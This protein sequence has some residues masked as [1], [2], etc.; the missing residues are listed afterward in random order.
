MTRHTYLMKSRHGVYYLRVVLPRH[1][2]GQLGWRAG[3]LRLSL[4]TKSKGQA[5]LRLAETLHT[6]T[7]TTYPARWEAEADAKRESYERGLALVEQFGRLNPHDV[8]RIDAVHEALS[9]REFR[10]LAY[11]N[12]YEALVRNA[13]RKGASAIAPPRNV[14][15]ANE[16]PSASADDLSI[17]NAIERFVST[18][19]TDTRAATADKYGAQCRLFL[20]M[21]SNGQTGMMI[22]E[23]TV[24]HLRDYVDILPKLPKK[25]MPEEQRTIAQHIERAGSSTMAP[26]TR[27]AHA[28]AVNMLLTW[29]KD[30][31]YPVPSAF[32]G[33]LK[34][35]RKKPKGRTL[36]K[37]FTPEEL[38]TIFASTHYQRGLFTR[39]SDYW[40]PLLGLFTGARK[41][42]S[43]SFITRT[44]ISILRQSFG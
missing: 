23:L 6:M 31:A 40:L 18:K 11:V 38:R 30:Q 16:T 29:A 1:V 25:V 35:L 22:S 33:I 36:E 8:H 4:R 20:R 28:Q 34:P 15:N 39:P 26:K 42:N 24:Q 19:K 3:E 13:E 10:D 41:P 17:A 44:S 12:E 14:P 37:H 21:V 27:F 43:A 2:V 32:E 9:D 7:K 5:K